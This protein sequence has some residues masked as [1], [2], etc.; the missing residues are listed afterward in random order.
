MADSVQLVLNYIQHMIIAVSMS[1]LDVFV[2]D[3]IRQFTCLT[4][5]FDDCAS[6]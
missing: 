5:N 3:E 4:N 2:S 6:V 1:Y